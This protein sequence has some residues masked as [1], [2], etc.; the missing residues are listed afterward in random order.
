M[1]EVIIGFLMIFFISLLSLAGIF[2]I[3]LKEQTLDRILFILIAF[4]TGTILATAL[5][6][7]IPEAIHHLE[8]LISE[9]F[10]IN[11]NFVFFYIIL[12]FVI[13]F[14]INRFIYWFHGH[15]HEH[16]NKM[17]CYENVMEGKNKPVQEKQIKSFALLNLFGDGMHNF[18]DGVVIMVAF[19]NGIPLRT[20]ARN[21][22][23]WYFSIW[24]IYKEK[25]III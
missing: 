8:E 15:A 14:I 9:G 17:V 5:F 10:A 23:F 19:M 18:L 3:S 4:A 11:E 16:D 6:D 22:R 20:S 2:M 25:S 13:F 21:W 24:R 12:G 1:M 7:L